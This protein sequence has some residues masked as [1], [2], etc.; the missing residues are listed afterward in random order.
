MLSKLGRN[1]PCSCGSG[2]KYKRCCLEKNQNAERAH[3]ELVREEPQLDYSLS[4]PEI[5]ALIDEDMV[6]HN[7]L[8]P[9]LAHH[10]TNG[11]EPFFEEQ[12]II[13][14]VSLWNEFSNE[15]Q[16][17]FRKYGTYCAALEY[18]VCEAHGYEVTQ[19]EIANK[20]GVSPATISKRFQ[21]L[22]EFAESHYDLLHEGEE[23]E[24]EDAGALPALSPFGRAAVKPEAQ[25]QAAECLEMARQEPSR[26]Q[27]LEYLHQA[28]KLNPYN[29]DVYLILSQFCRTPER[30]ITFVKHGLVAAELDLG[31]SFIEENRGHFWLISETRPYMRIKFAYAEL[32]WDLEDYEEALKHLEDLLSLSPSDNIGARYWL[33]AVYLDRRRLDDAERLLK[34]YEDDTDSSFVYDRFILEFLR[35][36][37]SAKLTTLY[38]N[39]RKANKHVPGYLFGSK[40]LPE[41]PS[42]DY[43]PGDADE[44]AHYVNSHLQL[45]IKLPGLL[46]WMSGQ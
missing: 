9:Q 32:C 45:W 44:A 38:R 1:D 20:Y 2:Q 36:G 35:R 5:H 6:W 26:K 37:K 15:R 40:P 31:E 28:L 39:A 42:D 13:E 11:M 16:P 3:L 10:L 17:I 30:A 14:A 29:A 19:T 43:S 18:L 34:T 4:I 46:E 27:Q 7:A 24:E 25:R 21:E 23:L 8:Y 12:R 22:N 41:N 33:L